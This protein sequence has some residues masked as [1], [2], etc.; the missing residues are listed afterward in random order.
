[1]VPDIA[2]LTD[3][4]KKYLFLVNDKN[5]VYRRDVKPGR[6][7]DDGMRV[8]VAADSKQQ[9]KPSDWII[10]NGLQ[11]ARINTAVEPMD[12]SGNAIAQAKTSE[13]QPAEAAKPHE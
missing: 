2:I 3:Q 9:L 10:V 1:V 12:G 4:D 5:V 6:L 13:P 8:V 11:R 7:L